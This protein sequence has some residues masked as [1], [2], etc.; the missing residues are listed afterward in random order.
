[1]LKL[2]AGGYRQYLL[3]RNNVA[4]IGDF[5]TGVPKQLGDDF[6]LYA[7]ASSWF[8]HRVCARVDIPY[9]WNNRRGIFIWCSICKYESSAAIK[10]KLVEIRSMIMKL[11]LQELRLLRAFPK[12]KSVL[13]NDTLQLIKEAFQTTIWKNHIK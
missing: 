3:Q 13:Y 2:P 10:L 9:L 7:L 8:M 1:M 4:G 5:Y 6:H 12:L 11:N